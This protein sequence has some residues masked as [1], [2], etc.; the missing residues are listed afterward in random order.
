LN[1]LEVAALLRAGALDGD[2]GT[3]A[4][5]PRAHPEVGARVVEFA[6]ACDARY[7]ELVDALAAEGEGGRGVPR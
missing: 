1:P 4:R 2:I 5:A 7:S 3:M 6:T